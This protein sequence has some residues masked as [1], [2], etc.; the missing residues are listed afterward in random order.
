MTKGRSPNT[1]KAIGRS[2]TTCR[3]LNIKIKKDIDKIYILGVNFATD[4]VFFKSMLLVNI[5]SM[6]TIRCKD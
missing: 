6:S 5:C 1:D 3:D 2:D 4:H